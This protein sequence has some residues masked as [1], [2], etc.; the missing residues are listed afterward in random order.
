[1]YSFFSGAL[2]KFLCSFDLSVSSWKARC[3]CA[4]VLVG[5]NARVARPSV[6]PSV[7]SVRAPSYLPKNAQ[8]NQNWRERPPGQDSGVDIQGE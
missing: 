3:V 2:V 6:R 7:S 8:E 4:D 1:M 5:R